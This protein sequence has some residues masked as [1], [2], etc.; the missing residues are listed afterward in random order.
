MSID[1]PVKKRSYF[2][3]YLALTIITVIVTVGL[4]ILAYI[5]RQEIMNQE[6]AR[7]YG[8]LGVFIVAFVASSTFSIMPIPVPYM[9]V[10]ATSPTLLAG[11]FGLWAPVWVGLVTA[12]GATIGQFITFM[13]GYSGGNYSKKISQRVSSSMFARAEKWVKKRGG[14]GVFLMSVA[15]NP[16]HLPMTLAFAAFRYPPYL[17]A[18]FTFLGVLVKSMAIAFAGYYSLNTFMDWVTYKMSAITL[19][20]TLLIIFLVILAAGIWQLMVLRRETIDKNVKYKAACDNAENCGK[21]VL[22]VGGPWGT[23]AGRRIF[24]KPAHGSGDVCLDIDPRA[25]TGHH[26]PVVASA[27]HIPFADKTFGSV[28]LSHVL[29]H[30]P[31]VEDAKQAIEE[32]KRVADEVFIVYPSRQSIGGWLTPG[33]HLWVWQDGDKI[34]LKQRGELGNRENIVVEAKNHK[35]S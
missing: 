24:K 1:Q 33:H 17:F 27:T 4:C 21:P 3:R 8:L 28:F 10:T 22:V 5:Y 29:E 11:Q 25:L 35:T 20:L 26:C 31:T 9:I 18:V 13:I 2:N 16:L 7:K 15:A 23:R 12:I 6:I 34:Y 19:I 30:L 32:M 14:L